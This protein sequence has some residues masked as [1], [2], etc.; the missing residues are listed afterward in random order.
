M[1]GFHVKSMHETRMKN[2]LFKIHDKTHCYLIDIKKKLKAKS[3]EKFVKHSHNVFMTPKSFS[4]K[5]NCI[6]I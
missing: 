6:D 1:H 4:L 2:N 3:D 5:G